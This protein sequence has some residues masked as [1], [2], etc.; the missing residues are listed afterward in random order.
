MNVRKILKSFYCCCFIQFYAFH[1]QFYE[2]IDSHFV[3][4]KSNNNGKLNKCEVVGQKKN[5]AFFY[6]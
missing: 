4:R 1:K 6:V 5:I 2:V 3:T